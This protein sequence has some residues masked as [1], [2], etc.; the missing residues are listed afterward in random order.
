MSTT[1]AI[2]CAESLTSVDGGPRALSVAN[3]SRAVMVR[4]AG[5]RPAAATDRATLVFA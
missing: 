2:S 1:D 4:A 3:P 5:G